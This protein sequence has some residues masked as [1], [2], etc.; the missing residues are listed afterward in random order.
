MSKP[1][2]GY[3]PV[4]VQKAEDLLVCTRILSSASKSCNIVLCRCNVINSDC[5]LSYYITRKRRSAHN[6]AARLS[7][8]P[9]AGATSSNSWARLLIL[10]RGSWQQTP[11]KVCF[12]GYPAF[13]ERMHKNGCL[14]PRN[15]RLKIRERLK[16]QEIGLSNKLQGVYLSPH[17]WRQ[18]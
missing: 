6:P 14:A 4:I 1:L 5:L 9:P 13:I 8:Q 16:L 7:K 17:K 12:D 11:D 15:E 18:V 3:S 10:K 2:A